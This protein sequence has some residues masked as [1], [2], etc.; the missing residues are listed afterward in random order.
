MPRT[1]EEILRERRQL[2][3]HYGLLFDSVAALLFRH[4]PIGIAFDNENVDEYEPEAGTILP[5]LRS[6]ESS[7][8]ALS[9][10]HEEFVRWFDI[11]TAGPIERYTEMASEIWHL[12]QTHRLTLRLPE[13]DGTSHG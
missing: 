8:D 13:P 5:R 10:I 2:R 9:V 4:D 1:R 12:W 6:C 3:V 7:A 11:E